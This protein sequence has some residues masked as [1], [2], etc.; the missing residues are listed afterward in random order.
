MRLAPDQSPCRILVVDDDGANCEMLR[1]MLMPLGFHVEIVAS[2]AAALQRIQQAM[3]I[4]VILM[5]KRMPD[6]DGYET[7]RRLRQLPGGEQ[8]S[9]I[10]VT[11]TGD[12]NER[13]L[14]LAVGAK[15]YVA[16]PVHRE[17]LLEEIGRVAGLH[18]VYQTIQASTT[19]KQIHVEAAHFA[20]LSDEICHRL[21]HALRRGDIRTLRELVEIIAH[22]DAHLADGLRELVNTYDYDYLTRLLESEKG[23]R[24]DS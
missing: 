20:R 19:S 2:G 21:N 7:T 6:L 3:D 22:D 18:Y 13:D 17:N 24:N 14:A 9:V 4:E 12:A 8:V 10:I 1:D 11:A 16:K 23:I 5:D 15:G